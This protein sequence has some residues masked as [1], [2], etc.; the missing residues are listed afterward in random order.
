MSTSLHF[1]IVTFIVLLVVI[2]L[3]ILAVLLYAIYGY[4]YFQRADAWSEVIGQD[5]VQSIVSG[6]VAEN[7]AIDRLSKKPSFRMYFLEKLVNAEGKFSGMASNVIRR[8]F[9][10]YH[11]ENEALKKL[12]QKK[13]YLIAGGI[14]ELTAMRAEKTLPEISKFL[15]HSSPQVYQE[16]QYAQV[17]L[18]GF[19]GLRFLGSA[20]GVLSDWQ[21]LRLLNSVASV[22]PDGTELVRSWLQSENASVVI[23][24]LRLIRKF[25][26]LTIYPELLI[27]LGHL[28]AQV[29]IQT[30][31]TLQ[32]LENDTTL[33]ELEDTFL[34]QPQEVQVEILNVLKK[35]GDVRAKDFLFQQLHGHIAPAVRIKAAEAI[36]SLGMK[37]ELTQITDD[38]N[39]SEELIFI[40]KHALQERK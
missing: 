35:M 24:T 33:K 32:A 2:A 8:I 13:L 4:R 9:S 36:H 30:V 25:Q 40:I 20:K 19:E 3:L 37:H 16:A 7:E 23:F 17:T 39:T 18:R 28:S 31:Q 5:V 1:L 6:E 14:Q 34:S 38:E 11:L 22:P 27:L 29:R 15:N 12:K 21:Q 10:E 26:L